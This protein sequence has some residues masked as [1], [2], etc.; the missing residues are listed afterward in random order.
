MKYSKCPKC[1]NS[2]RRSPMSRQTYDAQANRINEKCL[3]CGYKWTDLP[4][5]NPSWNS[6]RKEKL[7]ARSDD[8]FGWIVLVAIL[9]LAAYGLCSLIALIAPYV[10]P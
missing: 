1:G 6:I 8:I 5:D 7:K 9:L 2:L 10:T 4:H 3:Y